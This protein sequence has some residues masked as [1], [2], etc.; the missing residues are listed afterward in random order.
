MNKSYISL[1]LMSGTSGDG[2][3]ASLILSDGRNK[4]KV[5]SEQ[6]SKYPTE[7][8]EEF[9]KLKEKIL[10]IEDIKKYSKRLKIFDR[11]ITIWSSKVVANIQSKLSKWNLGT[12]LFLVG[13]HGQTILHI[14][15]KKISLQLGDAKLL[16]KLAQTRV[17]F[18][19]RNNDLK[20]GGQGAPLA[21]IFHKLLVKQKK[22]KLP[23]TILNLG[24]IANIT[25]IYKNNKISSSDIGPGNCLIDSWTRLNSKLYYD[26]YGKFASS[27]KINK[28]I[29]NQ[30]LENFYENKISKKKSFD[31]KDFD[32]SFVRGLSLEDGAATLTEFTAEICSKKIENDN[33]YVCGGGRKNKFLME[34]IKKKINGKIELIDNLGINGD[35][36]EAEAFAYLAIRSYLK[37]PISF[38]ET[39]GCKKPCTGGTIVK[40]Y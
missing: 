2:V 37:L 16:S 21:P 19:F 26:T 8:Y 5:I 15:E 33:V 12:K 4:F 18:K 34:K 25:S 38:P 13:F 29:L 1:G 30:K 40:N 9:H 35:F 32:L 7:I 23:I 36:V 28:I 14:P 6:Y 27:G 11:K 22:I 31:T 3:D 39:T 10:K 24:G 17:I 20:N